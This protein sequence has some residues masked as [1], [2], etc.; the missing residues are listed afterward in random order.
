MNVDGAF[1]PQDIRRGTGMVLRDDM[2]HIIISGCRLMNDCG[3]PLEAELIACIEGLMLALSWSA[4]PVTL[5]SDCEVALKMHQ[6]K[7]QWFSEQ[8]H[9]VRAGRALLMEGREV[10]FAKALVLRID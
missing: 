3:G 5:E 1:L 8:V 4:K 7:D 2:G 10:K 6:Q 9:L